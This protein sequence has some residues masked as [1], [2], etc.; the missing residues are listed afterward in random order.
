MSTMRKTK[1]S[2]VMPAVMTF[3]NADESFN[4]KETERYIQ[5]VL[6]CGA[7]S[8]SV[9]GSTG[10]N[11]A[12]NMEEQRE[13]IAHVSSFLAGQVPLVCGTGRYDTLN[14]I[15]MSKFAQDH[16]ADCVMVILPFYLNP[17]KKA[18][19]QHFRDIRA[20]LDIR[21]MIYNNPWFLPL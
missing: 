8:L 5:W 17:H 20:A 15:K 12:M 4:Q 3:W 1:G 2:G 7:H 14:T 19:L 18:V 13:I 10:E 16:G 6:D 9:T 11:I 21:M